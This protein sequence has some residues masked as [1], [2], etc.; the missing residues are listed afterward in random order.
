M[1]ISGD[2]IYNNFGENREIKEAMRKEEDTNNA[3]LNGVLSPNY[4]ST[5]EKTR[6]LLYLMIRVNDGRELRSKGGRIDH[7]LPEQERKLE[8]EISFLKNATLHGRSGVSV[9]NPEA[10]EA[11]AQLNQMY[12]SYRGKIRQLELIE[13]NAPAVA[14]ESPITRAELVSDNPTRMVMPDGTVGFTAKPDTPATP[15]ASAAPT[16]IT[17]ALISLG[18]LKVKELGRAKIIN[19]INT[20]KSNAIS[21]RGPNGKTP[22]ASPKRPNQTPKKP[23]SKPKGRG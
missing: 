21:A 5:T 23:L 7:L 20:L 17:A 15:A 11:L 9:P 1:A 10:V 16:T 13:K 3:I 22:V 19:L 6:Q 4:A 18:P 8:K 12:N 14:N 2:G